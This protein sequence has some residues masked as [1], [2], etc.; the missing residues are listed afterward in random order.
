MANAE[1]VNQQIDQIER[2]LTDGLLEPEDAK[3]ELTSLIKGDL[4]SLPDAERA[5]VVPRAQAL[6]QKIDALMLGQQQPPE[7]P[8]TEQAPPQQAPEQQIQQV[9]QAIQAAEDLVTKFSTDLALATFD[10]DQPNYDGS[11]TPVTL[12][13]RVKR[14]LMAAITILE[15]GGDFDQ[16]AKA[17]QV[18]EDLL[19]RVENI[20][21]TL[22][23]KVFEKWKTTV[24]TNHPVFAVLH[25]LTTQLRVD[26]GSATP[27][28]TRI[29]TAEA[30][31]QQARQ[32]CDTNFSGVFKVHLEATY[33]N[34]AQEAI[35]KLKAKQADANETARLNAEKTNWRNQREIQALANALNAVMNAAW[36]DVDNAKIAPMSYV[37]A[38][39]AL[40]NIETSFRQA[41]SIIDTQVPS[42]PQPPNQLI[43]H[44]RKRFPDWV[45]MSSDALKR[46]IDN[47]GLTEWSADPLVTA[48]KTEI[49]RISTIDINAH[50]AP[51]CVAGGPCYDSTALTTGTPPGTGFQALLDT[52]EQQVQNAHLLDPDA[53]YT[54]SDKAK[55]AK[56]TL[57]QEVVSAR[58]KLDLCIKKSLQRAPESQRPPTEILLE[59]KPTLF[60]VLTEM[61]TAGDLGVTEVGLSY[62][63]VVR[64]KLDEL[65]SDIDNRQPPT[66]WSNQERG[67]F[68][69]LIVGQYEPLVEY[70]VMHAKALNA[71]NVVVN[72]ADSMLNSLMGGGQEDTAFECNQKF[73][74]NL[75][76]TSSRIDRELYSANMG[77]IQAIV[78]VMYH[79]M[80][81]PNCPGFGGYASFHRIADYTEGQSVALVD[82]ICQNQ[83]GFR[84]TDETGVTHLI[85]VRN[86]I[87]N[88]PD[89][90][91][92]LIKHIA[93]FKAAR[94]DVGQHASNHIQAF[95]GRSPKLMGRGSN[96]ETYVAGYISRSMYKVAVTSDR[97]EHAIFWAYCDPTQIMGAPLDFNSIQYRQINR[98]PTSL[99][100]YVQPNASERAKRALIIRQKMMVMDAEGEFLRPG[101]KASARAL[102]NCAPTRWDQDFPALYEFTNSGQNPECKQADAYKAA[103]DAYAEIIYQAQKSPEL[104]PPTNRETLSRWINSYL[105]PFFTQYA[106]VV[107]Y[108]GHGVVGANATYQDKYVD[109]HLVVR[110]AMKYTLFNLLAN[111]PG[112][113][114]DRLDSAYSKLVG[115]NVNRQVVELRD[116]AYQSICEQIKAYGSLGSPNRAPIAGIDR[117]SCS[118]ELLDFLS[119]SRQWLVQGRY[120]NIS[121]RTVG[122]NFTLMLADP[123]TQSLAGKEKDR[124]LHSVHSRTFTPKKK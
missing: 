33:I 41:K 32:E 86:M 9:D 83:R 90:V 78:C 84:V 11:D 5:V 42:P 75:L 44:L 45:Q 24:E 48:L 97:S 77:P 88:Y 2:D 31:L 109:Y 123:K 50:I 100:P 53:S 60:S 108:L 14:N 13:T 111:I 27:D 25:N 20:E 104:K 115:D 106:L 52:A 66:L 19:I 103:R 119:R 87:A 46:H 63:R 81:D 12:F 99:S 56:E 30:Q 54:E 94:D 69:S 23:K 37:R 105:S 61:E 85:N 113:L 117:G 112:E 121:D 4:R 98:S 71:A 92:K 57:G 120:H 82:Y 17:S 91:K 65:I 21:K 116:Y 96:R 89:E 101:Y 38:V 49:G 64:R 35:D 39:A 110:A 16:V 15:R 1:G 6:K 62:R 40:T 68:I 58:A 26:I 122:F 28:F 95:E 67:A 76:V 70:G 59:Q 7:Q 102:F 79:L 8:R 34:P 43:D 10:P 93:L 22:Q 55:K 36:T 124:F 73:N 107:G 47:V 3:G 72:D 80:K 51:H 74:E 29:A 18:R 118:W 114:V